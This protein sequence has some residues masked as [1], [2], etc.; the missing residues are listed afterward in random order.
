MKTLALYSMK[1]GVGKTSAAVN[2]SWLAASTGLR[3]L[4]IDLDP[5]G[6]CSWCFRVAGGGATAKDLVKGKRRVSATIRETDWVR[7]DVL[8][9]DLSF[10]NLARRLDDANKSRR[11]LKDLVESFDRHY[12]VVFVDAQAS[13]GLEAEAVFRAA[14]LLLVPLVPTALSVRAFETVD[15]FLGDQ[16]L[17][18]GKL[19]PFFS[20][21]DRR[22]Q[23]HRETVAHWTAQDARFLATAIPYAADVERM[24][25][26]REP[27]TA[28]APGSAASRAFGELWKEIAAIAGLNG[29]P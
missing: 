27:L 24:S 25:V 11:R 18:R 26:V 9:A 13:L 21:V 10:R 5:Q 29:A 1:G 6:A 19:R 4:V 8:P 15:R 22:R 20:M 28:K 16:D 23:V 14:D 2:L 17:D 3:T 12:D 7:L